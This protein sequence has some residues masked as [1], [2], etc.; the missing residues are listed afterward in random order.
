MAFDGDAV[1]RLEIDGP[2]KT[3]KAGR[4]TLAYHS[5]LINWPV[6]S[7][8]VDHVRSKKGANALSS[9]D[10]LPTSSIA[11]STTFEIQEPSKPGQ[12]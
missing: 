3:E 2:R 8:Q 5:N 12:L 10:C 11:R 7:S 4:K 6:T 9:R 1:A